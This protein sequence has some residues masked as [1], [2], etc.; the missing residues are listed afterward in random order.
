MLL[1]LTC[2]CLI[3][4]QNDKAFLAKKKEEEKVTHSSSACSLWDTPIILIP[5]TLYFVIL[6]A[7]KELKAKAAKGSIGGTGLKKSGKK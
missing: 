4:L 3:Y 7:L 2:T 5:L 1:S 6:Q